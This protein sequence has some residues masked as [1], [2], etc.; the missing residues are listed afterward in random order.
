MDFDIEDIDDLVITYTKRG[1]IINSY[2]LNSLKK[3]K[4]INCETIEDL[5]SNIQEGV[6]NVEDEN[7]RR[8]VLNWMRGVEKTLKKNE[9]FDPEEFFNKNKNNAVAFSQQCRSICGFDGIIQFM[10]NVFR[11]FKI[12]EAKCN[13][14]SNALYKIFDSTK[15]A[16]R[17]LGI[18]SA[19]ARTLYEAYMDPESDLAHNIGIESEVNY[20]KEDYFE[21]DITIR[22]IP[23]NIRIPDFRA[24][25]EIMNYI[26]L[27][28]NE[29]V[30]YYNLDKYEELV[31]Q[32]KYKQEER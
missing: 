32:A 31:E 4:K 21:K 1:A 23:Y 26:T 24:N 18:F 27:P 13:R 16:C 8:R 25:G 17:L 29:A 28:V 5:S 15:K 9:E 10:L 3:M 11:N 12:C 22:E 19:D 14:D 2:D 7:T 30:C 6:G 20:E